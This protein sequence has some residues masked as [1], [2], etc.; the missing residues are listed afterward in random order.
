MIPAT[1]ANVI[2][3]LDALS[4]LPA[5]SRADLQ[6]AIRCVCR[7]AGLDPATAAASDLANLQAR[8]ASARPERTGLSPARWSVL[9]SQLLRALALTGAA[10]P[11]QTATTRLTPPWQELIA[12]IPR[13]GHRLALSRFG[14]FCVQQA[15]APADVTQACFD[16]FRQALL[17]GSLVRNAESVYRE[18]A[19]AWSQLNAGVAGLTPIAVL[20]PETKRATGRQ[21]LA[22]FP[23]TFRDDLQAFGRW[24]ITA[25]PLDDQARARALRPQTVISYTSCLHT[26][27]DAAVRGG[28][29]IGEIAS[30][31]VLASPEIYVRILRRLLAD[32]DNKPTPTVHG[33][34]TVV[35]IVAR[36]WLRQSPEELAVLKKLKVK[37]PKLRSGLTQK[38]RDLLAA[39]DDEALLRRFLLLADQLWNEARDGKLPKTQRL[40]RAQMAL[41]I[42]TLQI[43]PLRRRNVCALVFDRHI[44]WPNGPKAPALIQVPAPEMKT[45]VDYVGELPLDLSRRLHHYRT[46]LAPEIT[47]S[48]PSHLFVT[49]DGSP[50]QQESVTNRLVHVLNK[51]LGL[52]MSMHQFRHLAGKLMLDANPGAYET[53]AQNLGHTGTKNVVRFYGGADTRRATRHHA[54]LIEKLREDARQRGDTRRRKT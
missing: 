6:S 17:E 32:R 41:L 25:D 21:P 54:R 40:V 19:R 3:A 7:V 33:V 26:A 29:P 4:Q 44:T 5:R 22:A 51:R 31:A 52:K 9:R 24:C 1:L 50:K 27:A 11:L 30:L 42:G 8:L 20:P 37:L 13:V 35:L 43:T 16:R 2:C 28:V 23:A 48:V 36:D 39:F 14:R 49:S 15:I 34:A 18:A 46:K 12:A 45:E 53:V 47:G 38:N 10:N